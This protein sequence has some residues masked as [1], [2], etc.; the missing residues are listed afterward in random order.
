MALAASSDMA[1]VDTA[2]AAL[3]EDQ[4]AASTRAARKSLLNTW[5]KLH[6]AAFRHDLPD[7]PALPLSALSI[8][9]VG[10]LFKAGRYQ[11]F[12][13]YLARAK[14][15]HISL[16][17]GLGLGLSGLMLTP[18]ARSIEGRALHGSRNPSTP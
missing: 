5:I 7:V 6:E 8:R 17:P 13:N 18:G 11:S 16:G 10:A 12:D 15:E 1:S 4:F 3:V 9:R 14:A 2:V